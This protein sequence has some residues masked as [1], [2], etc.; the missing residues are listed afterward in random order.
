MDSSLNIPF[1]ID[2]FWVALSGVP[3]ALLVTVVAMLIAVPVAFF[4]ALT[5]I[6]NIPVISQIAKIYVSFVRGT[7]IIIQIFV[8]YSFIP[9]F[10]NSIFTKYNIDYPI[11]DI[12]PLWYA[13]IIF[14][15]N[16]TAVL[17][18]VFRSALGT[19]DRGQLEAAHSVGLTTKQAYI[20][21]IIPQALVSA[22]PNICTATVNLIKATSL[23]YAIS[24]QE[25]TLRA[26][27]EANLGYNYLEAYIDIFIVY[28]IVCIAVEQLF[29]WWEKRLS[30]YK[31]ASA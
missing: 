22:L 5:R 28:L 4:F 21:I 7:P 27:V 10:L 16:T 8:L 6:N 30:R 25:I 13:F 9:I 1:L 26:K 31:M 19:V 3:T 15:F 24:L 20:R 17:I 18:E 23:G 11:Y 14:S 2:T 12:H 29:K